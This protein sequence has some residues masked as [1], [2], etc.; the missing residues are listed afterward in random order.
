MKKTKRNYR[1]ALPSI[2]TL[3]NVGGGFVSLLF[4]L[5]ENFLLAAVAILVAAC[6]DWFDGQVA[7]LTHTTSKFGMEMD[8][9][10]D[11]VSFGVAP[12]LLIYSTVLHWYGKLGIGLTFLYLLMVILRLARF[13]ARE[14]SR[15]HRYFNGLAT[16][17]GAGL[18]AAFVLFCGLESYEVTPGTFSLLMVKMP[19]LYKTIPLV[20]VLVSYLMV[21]NIKYPKLSW[22]GLSKR[23]SPGFLIFAFAIGMAVILRP[24]D[25][26]FYILGAYILSGIFNTLFK[27][28]KLRIGL[29]K[30][31]GLK[32]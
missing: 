18:L 7:R 15:E 29:I 8:S 12:G 6:F 13:N 21:S 10:A 30:Q 4:T 24:F 3:G 14:E 25:A 17:F 32:K 26:C 20:M 9:L 27:R 5:Q 1:Y 22:L 11:V 19:F 23:K 28:M 31:I 2:F 16:P